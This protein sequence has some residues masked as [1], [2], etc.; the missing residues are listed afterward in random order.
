MI[1]TLFEEEEFKRKDIF[2]LWIIIN[3]YELKV[4]T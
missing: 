1:I 4:A 3:E 2:R